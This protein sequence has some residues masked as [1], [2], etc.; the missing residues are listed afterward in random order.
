MG[1]MNDRKCNGTVSLM[2]RHPHKRTKRFAE[3]ANSVAGLANSLEGRLKLNVPLLE[4]VEHVEDFLKKHA[5][6]GA[7]FEDSTPATEALIGA[8]NP[9]H[10][11]LNAEP[12]HSTVRGGRQGPRGP[13][14]GVSLRHRQ[15]RQ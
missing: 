5:F 15:H 8:S 4:A 10:T 9:I 13:R 3:F 7:H 14:L 2:A 11:L 12:L 1:R 6:R